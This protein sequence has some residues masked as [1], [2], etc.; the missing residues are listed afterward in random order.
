MAQSISIGAT[1]QFQP[2]NFALKSSGGTSKVKLDTNSV[3]DS[4]VKIETAPPS[5]GPSKGIKL[6]IK[7]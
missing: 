4:K 6:D 7:A 1:T 3:P 5:A 2:G